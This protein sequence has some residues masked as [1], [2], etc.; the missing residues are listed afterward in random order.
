[1]TD[2]TPVSFWRE[3]IPSWRCSVKSSRYWGAT[4][5]SMNA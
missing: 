4:A 1:V 2:T 5:A 3:T